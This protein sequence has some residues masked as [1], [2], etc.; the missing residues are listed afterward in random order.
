MWDWSWQC[1]FATMNWP[2]RETLLM[3]S[4]ACCG[5]VGRPELRAGKPPEGRG[6]SWRRALLGPYGPDIAVLREVGGWRPVAVLRPAD[7]I[8]D[9]IE[10]GGRSL[11]PPFRT[12]GMAERGH[13]EQHGDGAAG[14][15]R[16]GER[17]AHEAVGEA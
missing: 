9:G 15:P 4:I 10:P 12:P 17:L 1:P 3:A 7:D 2:L 16:E 6:P 8:V 11:A 5:C 13:V 14:L